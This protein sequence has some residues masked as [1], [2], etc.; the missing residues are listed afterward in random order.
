MSKIIYNEETKMCFTRNSDNQLEPVM[1]DC[2][3]ASDKKL[4]GTTI[5]KNSIF[6]LFIKYVRFSSDETDK[7]TG[8]RIA[9]FL[10]IY[11]WHIAFQCIKNALAL[12]SDDMVIAISRQAKLTGL[13]K[14]P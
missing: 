14:T 7:Q 10:E 11:Q 4:R 9:G 1:Y 5:Q 12:K 3:F 6:Y 2:Y 13:I 8:T